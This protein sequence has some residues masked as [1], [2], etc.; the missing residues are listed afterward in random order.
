MSTSRIATQSLRPLLR[1]SHAPAPVASV[2]WPRLSASASSSSGGDKPKGVNGKQPKILSD[3]PPEPGKEPEDVRKHNE[4]MERRAERA[5]LGVRNED[6]E[7][8]K[9]PPGYWSGKFS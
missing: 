3:N 5:A 4:E 1:G 7:K 6:A 2:G 8:D 9:V